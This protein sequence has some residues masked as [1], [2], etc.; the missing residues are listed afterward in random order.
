[1]TLDDKIQ[2][3]FLGAIVLLCLLAV[4]YGHGYKA[5]QVDALKGKMFYHLETNSIAVL[6]NN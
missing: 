6:N 3:T 1:M 2:F 5:G 4:T